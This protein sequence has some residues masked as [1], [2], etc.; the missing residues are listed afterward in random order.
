MTDI[1]KVPPGYLVPLRSGP[2]NVNVA[3]PKFD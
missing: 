2:M 3:K 1:K